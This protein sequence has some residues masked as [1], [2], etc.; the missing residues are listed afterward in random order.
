[1]IFI[2]PFPQILKQ[3][4]TRMAT[5]ATSQLAAQLSTANWLRVRPMAM[6]TGPVTMGGK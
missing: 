5:M 3:T 4:T 2:M 1:M 6:I